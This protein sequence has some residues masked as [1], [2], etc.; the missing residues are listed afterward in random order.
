M[1]TKITALVSLGA[2]LA[3]SGSAIAGSDTNLSLARSYELA[4][5]SLEYNA[6]LNESN[7]ADLKISMQVQARYQ[8]N[9]RDDAGT[10]L[11]SPDDDITTG[12][13]IRRAKIGIKGKVTDNINGEIKFAFDRDG[14]VASL[15]NAYMKWSINEDLTLKVGQ[16][17][18]GL[19]R[20]E[21]ISST[22]Q[23]AT[24]RSAVNETFNQDFS[25]GVELHFGGE[26]WRGLVGFTDGFKSRNTAFNSSAEADYALNGRV[27]FLFGDAQWSQFK[28]FTSWRGSNAGGMLGAALAFQSAGDTNP[29]T[30]L[31][32][33]MTTG[34]ID[35]S[36][37]AD[38][39]NFYAAGVWRNLDNGTT[40]FNDYGL[41][42][43]GGVF[44]SDNNELFARWDA[45]L[46]DDANGATG[47]DFNS[48]TVGWNHYMIPESHAAKFT[49]DLAYYLDST[50]DS[51]VKTSDGH[52]LLA[53][54][55]DGQ[56][57]ITAQMQILF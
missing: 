5:T 56:I 10:T 42:A 24:D 28:Q 3:A 45:V 25:Q 14:G 4:T 36:Y 50:T 48:V 20:E 18:Q 27:E 12:F 11:A 41:I 37:V 9:A 43:Q 1:N 7:L 23:L 21:N 2:I 57:A 26:R 17:K 31:T 29:S 13:A 32:T 39:W 19:L 46:P 35:F 38:G 51:I 16:F 53:D 52:N 49:L 33:E 40:N 15:E 30:A 44:V 55:E 8:F 54:S 34:T 22:R 47:N 6:L